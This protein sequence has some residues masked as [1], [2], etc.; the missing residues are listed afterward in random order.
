MGDQRQPAPGGL[1][2]RKSRLDAGRRDGEQAVRRHH[3]FVQ[4][5]HLVRGLD[6]GAA[7]ERAKSLRPGKH[8]DRFTQL[9]ADPERRAGVVWFGRNADAMNSRS[10]SSSSTTRMVGLVRRISK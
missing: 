9:V 5:G 4:P 8:R 2:D 3:Q 1:A 7:E 10:F 6:Q